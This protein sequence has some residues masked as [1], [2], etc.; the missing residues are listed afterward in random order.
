V[1]LARVMDAHPRVAEAGRVPGERGGDGQQ[2]NARE[3]DE[4]NDGAQT[5]DGHDKTV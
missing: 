2:L 3:C 4:E 1:V 5:H